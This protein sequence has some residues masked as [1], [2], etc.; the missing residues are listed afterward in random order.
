MR[1]VRLHL[2]PDAL[3]ASLES[4]RRIVLPDTVQQH[5]TRVLRLREGAAVTVFDGTGGEWSARLVAGARGRLV[6][7]IGI[8][9]AIDRES[10]LVLTLWQGLARGERMDIVVQKA[11]ELGV[12]R[13]VPVATARSVVQLDTVRGE[14]RLAHWRAVAAAACEQCG[15]N[16]LPDIAA[17]IDLAAACTTLPK[18]TDEARWLLDP[19]ATVSLGRA[20]AHRGHWARATILIGPEG[21]LDPEEHAVAIRAGFEAVSFGPRVLRT[22]TAGLA[23]L[24]ALQSIGGDLA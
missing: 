2:P 23:V 5:V 11:T 9:S 21:G 14:R 8:H 13:L 6:A 16:R 19:E 20:V 3:D 4:G 17:P 22:E 10:P 24:A 15:R 1:T 7:E 18:A 12:T